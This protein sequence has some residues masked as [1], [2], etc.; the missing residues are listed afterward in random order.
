MRNQSPVR[1]REPVTIPDF[2][3]VMRPLLEVLTDGRVHTNSELYSVLADH[4]ELSD[5]ERRELLPSRRQQ[6]YVNRIAWAVIHLAKAGL[7]QRTDC[8]KVRITHRGRAALHD[9]PDRLTVAWL[10]QF[11]EYV[12]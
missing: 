3:T 4:F 1:G 7:V 2:Q 12:A 10:V 8:G 9:G 6:L 11:P 5:A